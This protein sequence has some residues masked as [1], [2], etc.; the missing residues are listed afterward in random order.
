MRTWGT[1]G[2]LVLGLSASN[3][4]AA[5]PLQWK[6]SIASKLKNASNCK[7]WTSRKE[8]SIRLAAKLVQICE[9]QKTHTPKPTPQS[10]LQKTSVQGQDSILRAHCSH[11]KMK[12]P[13]LLKANTHCFEK[14][15]PKILFINEYRQNI[16]HWG[17]SKYPTEIKLRRKQVVKLIWKFRTFFF[18]LN[19][20][21][22][23]ELLC[24]CNLPVKTK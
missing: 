8:T 9:G 11:L 7:Q 23:M 24:L 17:Y 3:P 19:G 4:H 12:L 6:I 1:C 5:S 15:T 2:N 16:L 21:L 13:V 18:F 22:L 20:N 14:W 10:R